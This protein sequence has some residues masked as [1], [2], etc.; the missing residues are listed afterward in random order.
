M[1]QLVNA[2]LVVARRD[3]TEMVFTVGLTRISDV[4][5]NVTVTRMEDA[6]GM[7]TNQNTHVNVTQGG[8]EMVLIVKKT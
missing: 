5:F 3:L 8:W 1:M 7:Q 4:T 2:I 6:F